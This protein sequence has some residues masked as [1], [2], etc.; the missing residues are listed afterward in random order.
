MRFLAVSDQPLYLDGLLSILQSIGSAG[1]E[2]ARAALDE[3]SEILAGA[4]DFDFVL[5]DVPM[6]PSP[7]HL[8]LLGSLRDAVDQTAVLVFADRNLPSV[9]RQLM[10]MGVQGVVPKSYS[11]DMIANVLRL[12]MAGGR[13]VPDSAL[14]QDGPG[15][16]D[17]AEPEGAPE[18]QRLTRRQREVL[19]E[20]GKGLSNNDIA[21]RLGIAVATVK[22]HV[23]AILQELKLRNRTEAAIFAHRAG[24]VRD[25]PNIF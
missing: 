25:E 7:T 3:A 14:S 8:D 5:I 12:V 23:N 24:L 11:A 20:L 22:L 10:E 13:F 1:S 21:N 18:L 19:C 15:M 17:V 9:F 16:P 6:P 4:T 2:M